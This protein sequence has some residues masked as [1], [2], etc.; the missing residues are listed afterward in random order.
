MNLDFLFHFRA[1]H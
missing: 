1:K